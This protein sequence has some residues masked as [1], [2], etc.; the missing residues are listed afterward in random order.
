MMRGVSAAAI[1]AFCEDDFFH[2]LGLAK[3]ESKSVLVTVE[4]A[5][6]TRNG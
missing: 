3:A 2:G 5:A 1:F 6:V 4:A